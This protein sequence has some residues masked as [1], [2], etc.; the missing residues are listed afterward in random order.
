MSHNNS[1]P[2]FH[3]EVKLEATKQW[4]HAHA[5]APLTSFPMLDFLLNHLETPYD[6]FVRNPTQA[7]NRVN[8]GNILSA[9]NEVFGQSG[10]NQLTISGKCAV[11]AIQATRILH[12]KF[13]ENVDFNMYNVCRH[14]LARYV[15]SFVPRHIT[16][17]SIEDALAQSLREL[18]EKASIITYFR[19]MKGRRGCFKG[20]MQWH[21]KDDDPNP[22]VAPIRC[23]V[24][25]KQN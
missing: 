2:S 20:F 11:L 25:M 13:P 18:A 5:N 23:L 14:R 1:T 12:A 6:Q 22:E 19:Y 4:R 15:R 7:L 16:P 24:L 9:V 17:I 8:N 10:N 21:L 3:Q